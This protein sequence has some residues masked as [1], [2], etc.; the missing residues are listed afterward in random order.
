MP[1]VTSNGVIIEDPEGGVILI[2]GYV[3]S[4]YQLQHA[5]AQWT[6]RSQGIQ[7]QRINAVAFLVP[8]QI[9]DCIAPK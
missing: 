6:K 9:T 5:E 4:V 7:A 8:D 2:G 1:E 3:T